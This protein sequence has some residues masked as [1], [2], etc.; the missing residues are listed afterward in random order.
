MYAILVQVK[1]LNDFSGVKELM[2]SLESSST[3]DNI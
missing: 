3:A 2:I 1:E